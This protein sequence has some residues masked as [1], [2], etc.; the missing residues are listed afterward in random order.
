MTLDLLSGSPAGEA[1]VLKLYVTGMGLRSQ[2]AIAS[3]RAICDA[4]LPGRYELEVVDLYVSPEAAS[5]A[6]II[7]A[8]TLVR[9]KPL[10]MRRLVGDLSD[11]TR[12]RARLGLPADTA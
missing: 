2:R 11:R 9:E 5:P 10:P 12:V 6:Q 1:Y 4:S 8:P 7:A 3:A